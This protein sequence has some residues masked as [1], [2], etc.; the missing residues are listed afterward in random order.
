MA[1]S[2]MLNFLVFFALGTAEVS[3]ETQILTEAHTIYQMLY[4]PKE[5]QR[6]GA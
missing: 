1:P 5:S 2:S 6:L 4:W 3:A